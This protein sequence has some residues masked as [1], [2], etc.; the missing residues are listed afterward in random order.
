MTDVGI[1]FCF[2]LEMPECPGVSGSIQRDWLKWIYSLALFISMLEC[3]RASQCTGEDLL[4]YQSLRL[5]QFH[6]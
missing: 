2:D 3:I 6:I 4:N 5:L 1:L